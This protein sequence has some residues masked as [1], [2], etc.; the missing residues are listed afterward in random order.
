MLQ[1]PPVMEAFAPED[2]RIA[3]FEALA[4][5]LYGAPASEPV[6]PGARCLLARRGAEPVARLSYEVVAD[7]SGVP[8]G[9]GII[10]HY[11]AVDEVAGIALLRE[12]QQRLADAGAVRVI[13][14]MNGSTWAR[15]RLVL[16]PAP[17]DP[18]GKAPPFLTEPRNPCE[19]NSH[20]RAVG[21]AVAARY[22]SRIVE[23][24]P[25]R[26]PRARALARRLAAAGVT[27]RALDL[28]RFDDAVA[29][30]FAFSATAFAAHPFYRP[31]DLTAFR[32]LYA[33]LRPLLDPEFVL[34]AHGSNGCL[35]GFAFAIPDWRTAAGGRPTRLV[36]KTLAVA[37]GARGLGLGPYLTDT[38]HA[39]AHRKGYDAV[40]HALMHVGND[41]LKLSA[42]YDSQLFRRY[43][44]YEW[45]VG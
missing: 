35:L 32:G 17:G 1:M 25:T 30:L 12:G 37:P 36:L 24:L 40:I 2:R 39:R 14:P 19:Y 31:I 11:E 42:H 6:V 41:S 8:G 21:F 7:L 18:E 38:I 5:H 10:G 23:D 28:A 16:P 29:D 45:T 3:A 20:L 33:R 13:G 34:L 4:Q 22:E 43:A 26:R 9:I 27:L 15:Y 44:L